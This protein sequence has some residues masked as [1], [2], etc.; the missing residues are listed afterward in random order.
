MDGAGVDLLALVQLRQEA[1]L[2]QGLGADGGDVHQRPGPPGGLL[3]PVYL[4]PGGQIPLIGG[5]DVGVLD[6]RVVDVGGKGGVAA[7]VGPVGVHHPD[8]RDRGVPALRVPEIGLEEFEI[9]QIHGQTHLLPEGG[10]G[11]LFHGRK[12]LYG[13]DIRRDGVLYPQGLRLLQ[14]GLPALHRVDDIALDRLH[15]G[16]RDRPV[17]G[18]HPGGAHRGPVPGTQH[19]ETLGRGVR[20]LVELPGQGLHGEHRVRAGQIRLVAH[21][22]HRGLGKHRGPGPGEQ[23]LR[24]VLHVVAAEDPHLFQRPDPQKV[25]AVGQQRGALRGE[26]GFFLHKYSIDHFIPPARPAPGRRCHG[27]YTRRQNGSA[28]PRHRRPPG[29]TA[30]PRPRR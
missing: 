14:S 6:H 17:E 22:V 10:E 12:A 29:R 20:P 11:V 23:L 4:H 9:V 18:V 16:G 24:G 25:P 3:L 7:V 27:A 2:F 30:D 26:A 1:P 13:L 5:P 19:L 15:V 8:L 21:V 28:P